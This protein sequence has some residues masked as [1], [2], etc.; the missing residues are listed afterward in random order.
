MT[1]LARMI[2]PSGPKLKFTVGL[3]GLP[4]YIPSSWNVKNNFN[5]SITWCKT[6]LHKGFLRNPEVYVLAQAELC[7]ATD[8]F[9]LL[10]QLPCIF[11][12]CALQWDRLKNMPSLKCLFPQCMKEWFLINFLVRAFSMCT[13]LLSV[14]SLL[15]KTNPVLQYSSLG[16]GQPQL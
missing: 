12:V 1:D 8:C 14:I 15:E 6:R 16:T 5:D 9:Y 13:S 10:T 11:S 3:P 2:V 4:F 7:S